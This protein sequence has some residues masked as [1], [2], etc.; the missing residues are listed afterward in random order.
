MVICSVATNSYLPR[1]LCLLR[2]V[3]RFHP[4]AR[5]VLCQPERELHPIIDKLRL[6]AVRASDLYGDDF[7]RRPLRHS[8]AETSRAI[9]PRAIQYALNMYPEESVVIGLDADMT[10][11]SPLVDAIDL[12]L[13][14]D[15][16]VTPH[17]LHGPVGQPVSDLI[18]ALS[19]GTY[20]SGF[21][22]LRR[23]VTAAS[24]LAWWQDK[25]EAM[26]SYDPSRGLYYEQKWLDAAAALFPLTVIRHHG[27]NVGYWNV[28]ERA[29]QW[30]GH[31]WE[32]CGQPLTCIHWSASTWHEAD[33]R[34]LTYA[35]V[36][37]ASEIYRPHRRVA[38]RIEKLLNDAVH[39][40]TYDKFQSGEQIDGEVRAAIR[41]NPRI[42][43]C[44]EGA[45]MLS[46]QYLFSA[47]MSRS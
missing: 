1:F 7:W 5:V 26:C 2:S 22:G 23:G 20:N 38:R 4:E 11:E 10:I 44:I 43:D 31:R 25:A 47:L 30:S 18:L 14:T 37:L 28:R 27:Y 32:A 19:R 13:R 41:S 17:Y 40:W 15:I 33:R 46:N 16:V 29:I 35:G 39:E 36:D 8:I 3:H 24:F 9:R 12:I 45:A 42:L 21:V 6:H 34:F